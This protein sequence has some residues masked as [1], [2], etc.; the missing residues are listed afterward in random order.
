MQKNLDC[1]EKSILAGTLEAN[2]LQE[3]QRLLY[4]INKYKNSIER[5]SELGIKRRYRNFITAIF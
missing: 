4:L 1:Q 5:L 3:T 2:R